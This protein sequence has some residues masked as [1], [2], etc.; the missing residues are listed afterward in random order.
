[1]AVDGTDGGIYLLT[2]TGMFY[3]NNTLPDWVALTENIPANT[4]YD[5][6]HPFYRDRELRIATARGVFGA[7]LYDTPILKEVLFY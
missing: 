7:K 3:R 6:I 4:D 2:R 5:F 1:M